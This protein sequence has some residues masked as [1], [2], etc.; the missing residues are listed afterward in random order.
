[1]LMISIDPGSKEPIYEQI[2]KHI[3]EE[4]KAGQI[5]CGTR[6]PSTRSL[7]DHLEVSRNTIDMAYGQLL[8]EGYIESLPKKGYYVCDLETLYLEGI[9]VRDT[10]HRKDRPVQ[11]QDTVEYAVD[12]SLNGVDMD[13]FPYDKWRKLMREC[14]MDDNK[15]L[16]LSG[17]HQGDL[18][19]RRAV[20]D[21]LYQSRGV[22]CEPSQ[23]VIGAGS[24]YML[25]LLSRI[26]TGSLKI[27]MENPAYMQAYTIFQS[28]GYSVTPV[29]LDDQGIGMN[30]IEQCDPDIVYVTPSHQFPLGTVMSAKRKL[31]L[32]AW[33]GKKENRYIIE[34]DYDSEFRYFGRPIPALQSQDPFERVIYIGTFS[35][36]VA[37]GIRLSYMVLP[38][39]LEEL[40]RERAGFY[41]STVSRI[42]Q[43]IICHF[44]QQGH[45]ERHL[46][47]MRKV[48]KAKHDILLQQ[49]RESGIGMRIAGES[50]G[51]HLLLQ[52]GGKQSGADRIERSLTAAAGR[53]GVKVYPL[54]GY[55]ITEEERI[56]TILIGFARLKEEQLVEGVERLKRAWR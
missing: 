3:R 36:A 30:R 33:A 52:F 17:S 48:Y 16:F 51:L 18:E 34:D 49:L 4:I 29:S 19:L 25:L 26:L 21:Y 5:T 10:A 46:N 54:S 12:F 22:R 9:T 37:P 1:M 15:D 42:D 14:L 31:Q 8:S 24:D 40:Y 27:A 20:G 55:Y 41:F 28:L 56:P 35:K 47:R 43:N 50:A 38:K 2:Y 45:F 23:I 39:P 7:A 53:A 44:L 6:L 11:T 32:L 13:Y